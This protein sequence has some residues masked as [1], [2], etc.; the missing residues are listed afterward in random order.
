MRTLSANDIPNDKCS[1]Q[2]LAKRCRAC[3]TNITIREIAMTQAQGN[4]GARH[5]R[6]IF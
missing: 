1:Y 3:S 5:A 4:V 2:V 6:L